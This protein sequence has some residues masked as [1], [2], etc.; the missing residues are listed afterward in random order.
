[1]EKTSTF[2]L[3]NEFLIW[4]AAKLLVYCN[5]NLLLTEYYKEILESRLKNR[6]TRTH[7]NIN[8]KKLTVNSRLNLTTDCNKPSDLRLISY[9]LL[10]PP[11]SPISAPLSIPNS[12]SIS[13]TCLISPSSLTSQLSSDVKTSNCTK[14]S[15]NM[16]GTM[17]ESNMNNIERNTP[18]SS[19]SN[20][21]KK[22]MPTSIPV[23]SHAVMPYPGALAT[24]FFEGSNVTDFFNQ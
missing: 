21:P 15:T 3:P 8:S 17:V 12:L 5:L 14:D 22:S 13:C 16:A 24:S 20:A 18:T 1:M 2:G 10:T 7:A 23:Y 19:N 4:V 6:E 9:T 11:S